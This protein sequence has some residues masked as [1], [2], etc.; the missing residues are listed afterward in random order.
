MQANI[1]VVTRLH[2]GDISTTMIIYVVCV[3]LIQNMIVFYTS[4]VSVLILLGWFQGCG[5][6][7]PCGRNSFNHLFSKII[8]ALTVAGITGL[9]NFHKK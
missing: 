9:C 7:S 6:D 2:S 5:F 4:Q 1:L 3:F 8:Q